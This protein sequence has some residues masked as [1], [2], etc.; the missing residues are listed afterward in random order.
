MFTGIVAELGTVEA[1]DRGAASARITVAGALLAAVAAGDSVAVNGVCLTATEV[2][3][4]R[5]VTDVMAET[6][7]R[8][9]L[10]SLAAGDP[11]NL[12][13]P[14]TP[15]SLLG[16]HVVQGHVDGIGTVAGR[17]PGDGWEG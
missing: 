14:V 11:V 1:V 16:G 15:D 7:A 5:V 12:E 4:G 9:S 2:S 10:D 3:D 6:L 13:L 8:S 17:S